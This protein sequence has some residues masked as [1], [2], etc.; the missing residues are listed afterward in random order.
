M[1]R[2][3]WGIGIAALI[4]AMPLQA[5]PASGGE[6]EKKSPSQS[7][8]PRDDSPA[9]VLTLDRIVDEL[10]KSRIEQR[11]AYEQE[12]NKRERRDII[13]Q[14][15]MAYWAF[16]MLIVVV[17]QTGLALGALIALVCDLR[18]NRKSAELQL[19]AYVSAIITTLHTYPDGKGGI[20]K[21]AFDIEI[22][23]GGSTP[24]Y[25]CI[26][27]G[28]IVA[29][30]RDEAAAFFNSVED[31]P[32]TGVKA[33][34]VLHIGQKTEGNMEGHKP[35]PAS[36]VKKIYAGKLELYAFGFCE[37]RDTFGRLRTTRFCYIVEGL[38][39]ITP[40]D[41]TTVTPT[42]RPMEWRMAPFHNSAT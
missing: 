37:Y 2:G 41:D 14:E 36:V 3:Y 17:A 38:P 8:T 15:E 21:L 13:A 23:N 19:R 5:Q 32:R 40:P 25:E 9:V 16:W 6:G 42:I 33:S 11:D 30:T 35:F 22:K 34:Y 18:Q 10:E 20:R 12:R 7:A 26:H 39:S 4:L 29:F 1:L 24:A 28:N 31:A 27:A